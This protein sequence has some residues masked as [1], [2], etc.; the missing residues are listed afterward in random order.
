LIENRSDIDEIPWGDG[1]MTEV[2]DVTAIAKGAVL[3][4]AILNCPKATLA[5][6]AFT[7]SVIDDVAKVDLPSVTS[8]FHIFSGASI[9]ILRNAA[10][11]LPAITSYAYSCENARIDVN[12]AA[13]L[14]GV[15]KTSDT[16]N[17]ERAFTKL[18]IPYLRGVAF[19]ARSFDGGGDFNFPGF[20]DVWDCT[21]NT[22]VYGA[23]RSSDGWP[24]CTRFGVAFY[25]EITGGSFSGDSYKGL[26]YLPV[27]EDV[28]AGLFDNVTAWTSTGG[29]ARIKHFQGARLTAES[30]D[31]I[32]NS[33]AACL[34]AGG[35]FAVNLKTWYLDG[36]SNS[37]PTS[38]SAASLAALTTA[39]FTIQHN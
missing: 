37:A 1:E 14:W 9:S 12:D 7:G 20:V 34:A 2:T 30:V 25:G 38:A 26:P 36:G 16:L 27:V 22:C 29:G 28:Q 33:L 35:A 23:H 13:P 6:E 18:S 19:N 32:I 3:K 24:N 21:S 5:T 4:K 31:N 15:A 39:G 8:V 17:T 11:S 10:F